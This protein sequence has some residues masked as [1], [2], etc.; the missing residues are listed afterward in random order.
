[1][2]IIDSVIKSPSKG[3]DKDAVS[4][5]KDAK[6][7]PIQGV[8]GGRQTSL[9]SWIDPRNCKTPTDCPQYRLCQRFGI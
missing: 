5:P 7:K 3:K 4:H 2:P 8:W 6:P 9:P 1:M